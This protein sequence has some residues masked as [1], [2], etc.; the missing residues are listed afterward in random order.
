MT[1]ISVHCLIAMARDE[2]ACQRLSEFVKNLR[3]K[4]SRNSFANKTGISVASLRVYE[5]GK[6]FPT[7]PNLGLLAKEASLTVDELLSYLQ[8]GDLEVQNDTWNDTPKKAEDIFV[9]AE[10]QLPPHETARLI[11]MLAG[12]LA[13]KI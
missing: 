7:S 6:G 9:L 4:A 5:E 13:I 8:T 1:D 3:G 12:R 11:Q 2:A 10:K